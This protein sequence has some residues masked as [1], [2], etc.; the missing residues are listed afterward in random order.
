MVVLLSESTFTSRVLVAL[1]VKKSGRLVF[2]EA[3]VVK[4]PEPTRT[5]TLEFVSARV[6]VMVIKD[7]EFAT[8][9]L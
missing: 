6:G 3:I 7:T 2:P 9:A 4:F 1:A 5:A 8:V